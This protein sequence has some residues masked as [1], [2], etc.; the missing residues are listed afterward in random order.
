[1]ENLRDVSP[2]DLRTAGGTVYTRSPGGPIPNHYGDPAAEYA[3]LKEGA[4][5]VDRS[6]RLVLRLTGKDPVGMLNAVLTNEVS[7]DTNLGVYAAL[8]N[9]KGRIQT[10]LRVLK[11]AKTALTKTNHKAPG[12][13]L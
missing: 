6:D 10:D 7:Q 4:A 11:A 1:M 8:L 5:I 9:P 3:A 2:R 12:R 13:A